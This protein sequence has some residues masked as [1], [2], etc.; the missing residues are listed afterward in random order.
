MH[1]AFAMALSLIAVG[2]QDQKSATPWNVQEPQTVP[3]AAEPA[4]PVP[5]PQNN[6]EVVYTQADFDRGIDPDSETERAIVLSISSW[7]EMIYLTDGFDDER[8]K[9]VITFFHHPEPGS[10]FGSI[11]LTMSCWATRRFLSVPRWGQTA[12][13]T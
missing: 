12:T 10:T 9:E 6:A 2:C 7:K 13:G 4:A 8:V 5:E 1:R 11:L 3:R